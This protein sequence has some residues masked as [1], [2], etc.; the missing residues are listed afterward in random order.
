MNRMGGGARVGLGVG[1]AVLASSLLYLW[2]VE[3]TRANLHL[4]G[5]KDDYYNLLVRGFAKGHLFMDVKPDP[6]L[7]ALPIRERPGYAPF[8][9]DASLYQ[10]RYYLYFGIAP[11]LVVY[12]PYFLL[13]GQGFPEAGAALLFAL[14]GMVFSILWWNEARRRFF[15]HLGAVWGALSVFAL[16]IGSGVLSTLRRPLFYEVAITSGFAFVMLSLWAFQR[17]TDKNSLGLR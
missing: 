11:A 3:T 12:L 9:L 6:A 4:W 14:A 8:L 16:S 7:L 1:F 10:D 5:P 17:A 15:P 2:T 13:T